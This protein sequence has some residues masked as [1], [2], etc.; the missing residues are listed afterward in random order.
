[1]NSQ[2]DATVFEHAQQLAPAERASYLDR[3]CGDDAAAAAP[4]ARGSSGSSNALF[5]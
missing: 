2:S 4:L 5:S 1:M 3:T